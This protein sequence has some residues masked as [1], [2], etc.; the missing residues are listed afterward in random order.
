MEREYTTQIIFETFNAP[1]FYVAPSPA[2]SLYASGRTTGVVVQ[3][4]H[5]ITAVVPIHEGF[6]LPHAIATMDIAGQE[7]T[8]YLMALRGR[9]GAG[10]AEHLHFQGIKENLCDIA[11]DFKKP[12]TRS[13]L[14]SME[15]SYKL[16]DGQ[17]VSLEDER[18]R[19]PEALFQ[20][21]FLGLQ[22]PGLHVVAFN[23]IMKCNGDVR[24]GMYEN[25]VLVSR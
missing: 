20:P 21:A 23:S 17:I 14:S 22:A 19:V 12:E 15:K 9:G 8:D 24:K 18:F 16:P 6:A 11:L 4:G 7:L 5:N 10:F 1:A 13:E 2:L 25:I 3:S